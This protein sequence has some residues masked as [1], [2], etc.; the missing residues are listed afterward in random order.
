MSQ[1][2]DQVLDDEYAVVDPSGQWV[3][4]CTLG[5]TTSG[6][7][8]IRKLKIAERL[9]EAD[10][11]GGKWRDI[12]ARRVPAGGITTRF[13][14]SLRLEPLRKAAVAEV[15]RAAQERTLP[16]AMKP[17]GEPSTPGRRRGRPELKTTFYRK[18]ARRWHALVNA[19]DPHPDKTLAREFGRSRSNIAG[20]IRRCRDKGLIPSTNQRPSPD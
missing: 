1:F 10:Y 7:I 13:L 5:V 19:R 2:T 15:F 3:V 9:T 20:V 12:A 11:L 17:A 6:R 14:Q 4:T 8:A 16:S 18:V